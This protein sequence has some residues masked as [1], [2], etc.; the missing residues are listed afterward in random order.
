MFDI[1]VGCLALTDDRVRL[2]V[3]RIAEAIM[4]IQPFESHSIELRLSSSLQLDVCMPF[5]SFACTRY[6]FLV[7]SRARSGDGK[8]PKDNCNPVRF[9]ITGAVGVERN[10]ARRMAECCLHEAS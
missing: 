2:P 7:A 4:L 5:D 6:V 10:F 9:S 3:F 8:Q 1:G